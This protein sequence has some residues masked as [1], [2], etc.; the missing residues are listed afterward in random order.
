MAIKRR[1]VPILVACLLLILAIFWG[2]QVQKF[3]VAHQARGKF[4]H[5]QLGTSRQAVVAELGRPDFVVRG[6]DVLT[7]LYFGRSEIGVNAGQ[8]VEDYRY[9]YSG[10]RSEQMFIIGFGADGVVRSKWVDN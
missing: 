4:D 6:E 3:R 8:V 7:K 10:F 5:L 9:A 2:W 1:L